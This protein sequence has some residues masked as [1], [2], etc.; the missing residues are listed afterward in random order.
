MKKYDFKS[1][2][3]KVDYLPFKIKNV[4]EYVELVKIGEAFLKRFKYAYKIVFS[5]EKIPRNPAYRTV[6]LRVFKKTSWKGC[7][8]SFPG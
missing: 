5:E 4:T 6:Y 3:L 8:I 1:Q 7:I 2:D